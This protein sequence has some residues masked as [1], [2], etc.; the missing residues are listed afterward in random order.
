MKT[1]N[2][3]PEQEHRLRCICWWATCP[4]LGRA[5]GL[6]E[7]LAENAYREVLR[8]LSDKPDPEVALAGFLHRAERL[9]VG[10]AA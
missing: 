6:D 7:A 8:V 1:T 10:R 9:G 3:T 4:E 2:V 5:P